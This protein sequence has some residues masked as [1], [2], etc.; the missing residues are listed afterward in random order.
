[1][2]AE[3][4]PKSMVKRKALEKLSNIELEKYIKP[5]SRFVADAIEIAYEILKSR[6][7]H[8]D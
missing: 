4:F 8:V 1:M 2:L 5:E 6:G 3:S 7:R